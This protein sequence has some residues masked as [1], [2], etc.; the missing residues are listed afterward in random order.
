M[1]SGQ[2]LAILE[3]TADS[4][5]QGAGDLLSPEKP[6][7]TV[8]YIDKSRG[9][10]VQTGEGRIALRRLQLPGK[11]ALAFKDFRNGVRDFMGTVLG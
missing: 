2:R 8:L 7:G 9:I 11:K 5:D 1:F 4:I 10:V 6:P 3:C